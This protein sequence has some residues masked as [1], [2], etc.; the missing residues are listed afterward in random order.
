MSIADYIAADGG[1][2]LHKGDSAFLGGQATTAN[3]N[4][5]LFDVYAA[6][7]L[8]KPDILRDA[9]LRHLK[10]IRLARGRFLRR[11]GDELRQS[12]DNV[13]AACWCSVFIEGAEYV[14]KEILDFSKWRL[15]VYDPNHRFSLDP[16]CILQPSHV[17]ILKLAANRRPGWL[18]C[19]W[20]S[21]ACVVSDHSSD[22]YLKS[23]LQS[24]IVRTRAGLLSP[25]KRKVA[26]WGLTLMEKRREKIGR[27]YREYYVDD[28]QHPAVLASNQ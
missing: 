1:G 28:P 26:L 7:A 17:F 5:L 27:W 12:H 10:I 19:L 21:A 18:S 13:L 2:M 20:F 3:Q 9:I 15:Y 14:A 24:D 4:P 25:L 6:R 23:M 16:R 8:G 11:K 22:S